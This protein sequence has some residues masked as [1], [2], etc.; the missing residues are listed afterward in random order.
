MDQ[1]DRITRYARELVAAIDDCPQMLAAYTT[2]DSGL[3][4]TPQ[5]TAVRHALMGLK[6][7]LASCREQVK[8]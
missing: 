1:H 2:P 8:P 4:L 3:G 6:D 7:A 5:Q